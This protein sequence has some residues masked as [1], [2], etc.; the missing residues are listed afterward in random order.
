[1]CV[2]VCVDV[3][4]CVFVKYRCTGEEKKG[5]TQRQAKRDRQRETHTEPPVQPAPFNFL[6]VARRPAAIGIGSHRRIA[7]A[8][9]VGAWQS[10]R[11]S[12]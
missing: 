7:G 4:V 10:E 5:H 1:M 12:V 8:V 2:D 9:A 6:P 11:G 3:C